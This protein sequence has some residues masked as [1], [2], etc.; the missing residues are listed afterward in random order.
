MSRE[1]YIEVD[2]LS[3]RSCTKAVEREINIEVES[4]SK[5]LHAKAVSE[6]S[7]PK[8]EKRRASDINNNLLLN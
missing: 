4:S 5:R 2:N 6:R 7:S 1:K 8:R 3:E